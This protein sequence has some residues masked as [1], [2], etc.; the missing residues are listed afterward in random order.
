MLVD[1]AHDLVAQP[2][3]F[4]GRTVYPWI[5]NDSNHQGGCVGLKFMVISMDSV[6]LPSVPHY[7][8]VGMALL[9]CCVGC[10]FSTLI[11]QRCFFPFRG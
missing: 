11:F 10:A 7:R 9:S 5:P 8:H 6:S 3:I 1:V 2:F 4:H